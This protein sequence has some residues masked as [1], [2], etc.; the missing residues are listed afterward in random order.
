MFS[1]LCLFSHH[2]SIFLCAN[3]F[4]LANCFTPFSTSIASLTPLLPSI[5]LSGSRPM[6]EMSSLQRWT[7]LCGEMPRRAAG[8]QQFHLQVRQGQQ[9][10]SSMSCQLHPGVSAGLSRHRCV[11]VYQNY[12]EPF[13]CLLGFIIFRQP[14]STSENGA[15]Q[16]LCCGF[17]FDPIPPHHIWY[18]A[19]CNISACFRKYLYYHWEDLHFCS[20]SSHEIANTRLGIEHHL[21]V[22]SDWNALWKH[23]KMTGNV[24]SCAVW[25]SQAGCSRPFGG[26][27]TLWPSWLFRVQ[28]SSEWRDGSSREDGGVLECKQK[29]R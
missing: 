4:P 28:P 20:C 2:A 1:H 21:T 5:L 26:R 3:L 23:K 27:R 25:C 18:R 16:R 19:F 6:C 12:C 9:R 11:S 29:I 7:E 17:F 10:V 22:Q 8:C 15:I 24:C 13:K 14:Q